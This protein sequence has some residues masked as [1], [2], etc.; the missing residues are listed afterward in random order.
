MRWIRGASRLLIAAGFVWTTVVATGQE[1]PAASSTPASAEKPPLII[2]DAAHGGS[3]PGALLTPTALEKDVTLNVARRLRQELSARGILCRL[4]RDG[5]A[6][7]T[8]DQRAAFVNTTDPALYIALHASSVGRGIRVFTAMLPAGGDSKGPFLDWDTAQAAA[9]D[10]S[11]AIQARF[12]AAI[13][14][15]RFPVRALVAPLRPLNNVKSPA[16]AIEISPA[17]GNA[18]Q[19]ASIGYQQMISS[20][21][22][23]AVA[24]IL[25]SLRGDP[26]A[27]P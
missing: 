12:V 8:T 22:A 24:S 2:I 5:D 20:A 10:R 3:D 15:T 25:P 16:I 23:N 19:V 13:Q 9:L 18:S 21:V 27:R 17:T 1:L 11:K 7:L 4:V 14:K 26:G 6:T